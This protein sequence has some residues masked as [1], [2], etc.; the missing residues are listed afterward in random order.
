MQE[1]LSHTESRIDIMAKYRRSH[2]VAISKKR[3]HPKPP[4]IQ[5]IESAADA[6]FNPS[7]P[8]L[9]AD[10]ILALG[11]SKRE[12]I[13]RIPSVG[14]AVMEMKVCIDK[15][16]ARRVLV[17]MYKECIQAAEDSDNAIKLVKS[18]P[19]ISR[20]VILFLISF[21]QLFLPETVISVTKMSSKEKEKD[22]P[23]CLIQPP[24]DHA[25]GNESR[26]IATGGS[27][28]ALEPVAPGVPSVMPCEM[29]FLVGVASLKIA[30][31]NTVPEHEGNSM[32]GTTGMGNLNALVLNFESA[33]VFAGDPKSEADYDSYMSPVI[34]ASSLPDRAQINNLVSLRFSI[35]GQVEDDVNS[36]VESEPT[37]Q[38]RN[39][40][41]PRAQREP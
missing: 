31:N 39:G 11:G 2:L 21:L 1:R 13:S 22:Q 3:P 23:R 10:S 5:E 16:V 38:L 14:D 8:A 4:T 9:L 34:S 18:L 30:G 37:S 40:H 19:T 35:P 33:L 7:T 24:S 32:A 28:S 25:L 41:A 17:E 20:R 15:D 12:G 36:P 27:I 6:A 29:Q 26:A